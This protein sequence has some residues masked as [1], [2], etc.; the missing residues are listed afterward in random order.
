MGN[1]IAAEQ[2][3]REYQ[4]IL[5]GKSTKSMAVHRQEILDALTTAAQA[6]R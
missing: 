6:H 3:Y 4:D 1:K 2:A 5:T